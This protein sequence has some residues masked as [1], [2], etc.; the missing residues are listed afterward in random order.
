[1]VVQSNVVPDY[2]HRLISIFAN[3]RYT[4]FILFVDYGPVL[5]QLSC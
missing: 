3:L 5:T 4:K 2:D 1:M